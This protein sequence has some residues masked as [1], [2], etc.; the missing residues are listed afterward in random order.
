[1]KGMPTRSATDQSHR[2]T[3]MAIAAAGADRAPGAPDA[4]DVPLDPLGDPS[5]DW[6]RLPS[7]AQSAVV[8]RRMARS[9]LRLWALSQLSE[10][11][12]QLVTELVGNVVRHTGA[13]TVGLRMRRRR[14]WIRVEVR[15]PSRALPCLLPVGGTEANG[16][17]LL[18]VHK[19]ADR[20]GVELLPLGKTTWFE[21]RVPER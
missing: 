4:A 13:G 9:V 18:L 20:W 21:L 19:L 5:H 15:D 2:V 14:G 7:R 6:V 16:R 3:A 8:C 10:T 11:V 1:M 12:E 17:G